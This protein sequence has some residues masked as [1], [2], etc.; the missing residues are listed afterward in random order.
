MF[1]LVINASY[2]DFCTKPYKP[3]CLA[4][5]SVNESE[6]NQCKQYMEGYLESVNVFLTCL[7]GTSDADYANYSFSDKT[8]DGNS[9]TVESKEAVC[10]FNCLAN[11][12]SF[13][14]C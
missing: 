13:C 9:A 3:D 6:F 12:E 4:K 2:A 11:S 5:I 8:Q 10:E 14:N 1:I 7:E